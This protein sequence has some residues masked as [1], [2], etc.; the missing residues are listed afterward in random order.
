VG[1]N[2]SIFEAK[3]AKISLKTKSNSL[4]LNPDQ[5]AWGTPQ[6]G[7]LYAGQLGWTK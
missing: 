7:N 1:L 5:S 3:S 4:L 2:H 6:N